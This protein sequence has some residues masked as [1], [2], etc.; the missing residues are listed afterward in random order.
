VSGAA[1]APAVT[2]DVGQDRFVVEVDGAVAQ[3]LYRLEPGRLI[4][5]HTR[6]P[7]ALG[8]RG[9]GS[10]LVKAALDWARDED[11]TV[12]PWCPFTRRWLSEHHDVAETLSIDWTPPP[13]PR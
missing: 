5:E 2:H 10:A 7:E 12:V 6:V 4:I 1:A 3:L 13:D 11:F 8:G 9:I